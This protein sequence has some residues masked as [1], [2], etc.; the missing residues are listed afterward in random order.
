[1]S[2]D[3]RR[4]VIENTLIGHAPLV[5]EIPLYLASEVIPSGA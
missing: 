2:E 3:H 4:F 5:P 1:M